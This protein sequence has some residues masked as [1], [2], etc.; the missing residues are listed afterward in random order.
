MK[1]SETLVVCLA[2]GG[3]IG[4]V[5]FAP[6]TLGSLPGILYYFFMS[7][8]PLW[9]AFLVLAAGILLAVWVAGQAE[10]LLNTHDPGCIVIDEIVG[11]AV[12]FFA[13]PFHVPMMIIGFIVFRFFDILKPFPIGMVDQRL[14]GGVGVV[15]DDVVAGIFSNIVLQILVIVFYTAPTPA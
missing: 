1:I 3:Y 5:P 4:R 2:T 12:T 13:I 6:G 8:K 11:M 9:P 7:G 15:A 14:S 10:K